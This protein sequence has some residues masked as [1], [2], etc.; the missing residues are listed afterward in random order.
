MTAAQS[1]H[2]TLPALAADART[3]IGKGEVRRIRA[4]GKVPAVAYGKTLK[5]TPIAVSPK[6]VVGILTSEHGRNSVIRLG[7]A[8]A[9]DLLVMIRD[10]SY[11]PVTRTLE[12]VDF[13]QV[14]LD[15]PVDV[16]VPLFGLGKAAGLTQGG[17]VRVVYR[18]VPVRCLPDRIPVKLEVDISHL[19]LGE[20]VSTQDLKLGAGVTVRLPPEQTLIAVVTPE[21]ERVEDTVSTAAV[22]AAGAAVPAAGAAAAP[23][24]AAPGGAPGAPAAK[25]AGAP[26]GKEAAPAKDA[27]K[28]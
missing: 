21:K 19:A 14:K 3:A 15:Q 27:K 8:G 16:D 1:T 18:T 22:P 17:I 4:A 6:D 24:G 20:H 5:S 9:T 13:V 7:L 26:A 12:H 28:K 2:S 11:H 10:Y 25:T 23:G